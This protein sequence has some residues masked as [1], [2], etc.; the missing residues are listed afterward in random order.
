[1]RFLKAPGIPIALI[2]IVVATFLNWA[3]PLDA[4]TIGKVSAGIVMDD[5]FI[6][7]SSDL[8]L[9]RSLIGPAFAIAL[10][11]A[12]ESL[13]CGVVAGRMT[14]K[15]LAVNQELIAQGVGNI[16]LPFVGGVPATAAI[17]R[18]SVGVKAG[19]TTRLV[20]IIHSVVLLV[21]GIFFAD[22]IKHIPVAA[23]SGVLFVTAWRM[24]EWHAIHFYREH[25]LKGA[26]ATFFVTMLA[27][28]E[29]NL[30]EAIAAGVLVSLALFLAQV[31]RL[32]V[33]VEPVD[34][35][36]IGVPPLP[37]SDVQVIYVSGPLFFGSVNQ[38]VERVEELPF[39]QTLILSMRGVPMADVSSV[40]AIDHLWQT[41]RKQGGM[42]FVTGLQPQVRRMME[43]SGLIAAMG[44]GQFL[45]S[46]DQALRVVAGHP[47]I[48]SRP[49]T[50]T[51]VDDG[52]GD[53]PLGVLPIG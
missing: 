29:F 42:V 27:T 35:E 26:I 4:G 25:R 51:A 1:P 16:V 30:S 7:K 15:K 17:A 8:D 9:A 36:K 38:F 43:R 41:H 20:A 53:L 31:A 47:A 40:Q 46:A 11:G 52:L 33:N 48:A 5:H 22:L 12:I 28:V 19:G 13:L 14:G 49:A 50:I 32:H 45:W 23:L 10:L 2:G 24:N 37:A 21:G 39:A 6:P 34:W 3:T 18:T 44:D